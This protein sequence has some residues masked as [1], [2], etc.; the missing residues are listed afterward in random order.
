MCCDCL[1]LGHKDHQYSTVADARLT[2]GERLEALAKLVSSKKEE[3]EAYLV[4]LRKVETTE[5]ES[6]E[7]MKVEVDKTFDRIVAAFEAQRNEALK[8]VSQRLKEIWA[9]KEIM[10][11]SLAQLESF[12]HFTDHAKQCL[13]D[14]A[15]VAMA[16]QG[17]KLMER[18]KGCHGNENTLEHQLL[19][20]GSQ[21]LDSPLH[22]P[23]KGVLPI[24]PPTIS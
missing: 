3:F 18:L 24:E 8:T 6:S 7:W 13:T 1:L 11:V 17:M 5:I 20:I 15:Y 16:T 23:L 14:S 12:T 4:K 9:Q 10:E 21:S 2:L 19:A 22:I